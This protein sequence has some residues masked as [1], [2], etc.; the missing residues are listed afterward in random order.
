MLK[1]A[2]CDDNAEQLNKIAAAVKRY[3]AARPKHEIQIEVFSAAFAFLEHL[4]KTGGFEI[5]L[6][7]ICMPGILGT[8]VA[9]EIRCRHDKTEIIFLTTSD[10]Y[11]VD[12]FALK[13]AHYLLKPF[14]QA[15]LDEAMDRAMIRFSTEAKT[16]TIRADDGTLYTV[17]LNDIRYIESFTHE[18]TFHL[19]DGTL[20]E[21]RR[22]LARLSKELETL[23]PGQFVSPYKGYVLNLGAVRSVQAD[24]VTLRGGETI[25][26]AKRSFAALRDKYMN[27]AF[28]KENT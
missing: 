8:E 28:R 27:F 2:I 15:Q 6:L 1:L 20:T 16:L 14:T 4:D 23:S 24:C 13:A 21:S 18:L 7:D 17:G 25:P 26:L 5:A 9:K 22:G 12:A 19:T 10:E 11:A 3:F